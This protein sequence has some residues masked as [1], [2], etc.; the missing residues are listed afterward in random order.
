MQ[1][2]NALRAL[3]HGWPVQWGGV[4]WGWGNDPEGGRRIQDLRL[5]LKMNDAYI[6]LRSFEFSPI[7]NGKPANEG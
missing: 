3:P 7:S 4:D 6:L 5:H 2:C 1:S